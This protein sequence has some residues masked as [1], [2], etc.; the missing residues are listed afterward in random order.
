MLFQNH[1]AEIG[2]KISEMAKI[3]DD[4]VLVYIIAYENVWHFDFILY[5]PKFVFPKLGWTNVCIFGKFCY[6]KKCHFAISISLCFFLLV[7]LSVCLSVSLALHHILKQNI[8][9]K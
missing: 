8:V 4:F 1:Y 5:N 2:L 9:Y 6:W 3:C 7:C